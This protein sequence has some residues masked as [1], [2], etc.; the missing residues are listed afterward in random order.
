MLSCKI[1]RVL[2]HKETINRVLYHVQERLGKIGSLI[3]ATNKEHQN[4]GHTN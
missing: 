4:Q 3:K 2:A 1:G